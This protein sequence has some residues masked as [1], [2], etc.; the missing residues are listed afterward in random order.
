M[1]NYAQQ[2]I[3]PSE[4]EPTVPESDTLDAMEEVDERFVRP[5]AEFLHKHNYGITHDQM[6]KGLHDLLESVKEVG[7]PGSVTLSINVKPIGKGDERQVM[8]GAVVKVK[9]PESRAAEQF[10][11]LDDEG[12]LSRNDPRQPE[13]PLQ[14]VSR[15]SAS[16]AKAVSR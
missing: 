12:N 9:S 16:D 15:P 7:K 1:S 13:L 5:F 10:Y 6:S 2:A 4:G 11:W 14:D 3:H 8:V